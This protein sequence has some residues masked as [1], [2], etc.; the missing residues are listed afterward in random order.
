[1]FP[2]KPQAVDSTVEISPVKLR[3]STR[4]LSKILFPGK[5]ISAYQLQ[6]P[7]K[8]GKVA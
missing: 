8:R 6:N 7:A 3:A 1:M 4:G 5:Q 2:G